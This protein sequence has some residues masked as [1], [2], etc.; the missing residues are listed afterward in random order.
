MELLKVLIL[1]I[2]QGVTEL[3]PISS[4]AHLILTAQLLDIKMDT[5]LLSVLHLGTTIALILHFWNILFKDIFKKENLSFYS[6]ILIS[7]IP[8]GI[9]GLLF[10][11][12]IEERLRGNLIIAISLI[13]W[14]IVMILVERSKKVEEQDLKS[15][16]WKQSLLMG[17]GQI[18]ALIPGGSRSGI[19]TIVGIL[20]GLNKYTAIQYSFLLGL[21]LLLA[22]PIYSIYK[23]YPQRILNGTGIL[24]IIIAGIFTFL[25]LSLLKRFSKEK[26][27]TLF[28]VYRI[29][30][31]IFVLILL[32]L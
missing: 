14:G 19:S 5:Y 2:E 23:E 12:V 25:S 26:W 7:T 22:A 24:G 8:A 13:G 31:G 27:L 21:P 1:G 6:K 17:V 32:L 16:T 29:V 10:E 30:L 4:S 3:L 28:G 15:V 20:S 11:S 18:F 9:V